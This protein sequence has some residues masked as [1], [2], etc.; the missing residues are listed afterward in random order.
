VVRIMHLTRKALKDLVKNDPSLH[1][2]N[3][4][5]S[6][7]VCLVEPG[8]LVTKQGHQVIFANRTGDRLRMFFPEGGLFEELKRT[9]P[10]VEV[11]TA[12]H[13]M[14]KAHSLEAYRGGARAV[15]RNGHEVLQ[16]SSHYDRSGRAIVTAAFL[17]DA[18]LGMI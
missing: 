7:K 18:L 16:R 3:L 11:Y 14:G 4:T 9:G 8:A 13:R 2:V 10:I 15:V 1:V 5:R 12:L 6:G 17:C